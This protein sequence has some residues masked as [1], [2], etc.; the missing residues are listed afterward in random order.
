MQLWSNERI[1]EWIDNVR[2]HHR[3]ATG[4]EPIVTWADVRDAMKRLRDDYELCL[5]LTQELDRKIAGKQ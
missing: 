4:I 5:R 1:D 2:E 3:Q